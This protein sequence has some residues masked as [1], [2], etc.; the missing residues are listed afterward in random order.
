MP[1]P[2]DVNGSFRVR[3]AFP[4]SRCKT[5]GKL[6]PIVK[7][8]SAPVEPPRERSPCKSATKLQSSSHP[9]LL[10]ART[11]HSQCIPSPP[12]S[13]QQPSFHQLSRLTTSLHALVGRPLHRMRNNRHLRL[14]Q[15]LYV[16]SFLAHFPSMKAYM[17]PVLESTLSS[18]STS[19]APRR[20]ID[21]GL[22]PLSNKPVHF[23]NPDNSRANP[24]ILLQIS[25]GDDSEPQLTCTVPHRSHVDASLH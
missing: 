11:E 7:K 22:N 17:V 12:G 5:Q 25:Q 8:W 20:L 10:S 3:E 6:N 2:F 23:P 19:T 16:T 9:T 15:K 21:A 4:C 13:S 1:M 18:L 24:V 14:Y